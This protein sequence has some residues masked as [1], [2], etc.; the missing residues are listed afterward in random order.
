M[1]KAVI[2]DCFGVVLDIMRGTKIQQ[3]L[4]LIEE[5]KPNYALGMLTNVSSR[6]TLDQRFEPGQL[7]ELFSV[8]VASGDVG[9]EKPAPELFIMTAEKLAVRPDECLFIDDIQSF[10]DAAEKLGMKSFTY[11]NAAESIVSI[12]KLLAENT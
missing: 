5:L 12:K 8:V 4:D 2:F 10:C 3:T 11:V 9:W 1:I 6:Y 7:D